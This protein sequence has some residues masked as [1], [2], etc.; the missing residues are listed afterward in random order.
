MMCRVH[1]RCLETTEILVYIYILKFAGLN[2]AYATTV[3]VSVDQEVYD[4]LA[5]SSTKNR[6]N[7]AG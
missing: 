2:P 7:S 4:Q 3:N 6:L 5:E 1:G